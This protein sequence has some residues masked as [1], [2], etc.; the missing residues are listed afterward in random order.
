MGSLFRLIRGEFKK[1]FLKPGIFIMTGLLVLV[2]TVSPKLFTPASR[3]DLILDGPAGQSVDQKL[4]NFNITAAN[5]VAEIEKTK[6][7][8]DFLLALSTTNNPAK[9]LND[10]IYSENEITY[11][12]NT[13]FK[14]Y[15]N[16]VAM[17]INYNTSKA[18]LQNLLTTYKESLQ[19]YAE[20]SL[21]FPQIFITKDNYEK[22]TKVLNDFIGKLA[23]VDGS[24]A[25]NKDVVLYASDKEYI[26]SIKQYSKNIVNISFS[27]AN[28]QKYLEEYYERTVATTGRL[29]LIKADLLTWM[30]TLVGDERELS[31]YL[32]EF[33]S[34]AINYYYTAKLANDLLEDGLYYDISKNYSD[35]QLTKYMGFENFSTYGTKESFA[36][37]QFLFKTNTNN[38]NYSNPFAFN[39]NSTEETNG[40]DYMYFVLEVMS[41]IIITY[42][43]VL[44]AGMIASEQ[45][46]GTLKMLAIRPFKRWKI[47]FAKIFTTMFFVTIFILLSSLISLI[48]GVLAFDGVAKTSLVVFNGTYAFAL[49]PTLLFFIYLLSLWIKVFVFVLIAFAISTLFKTHAGSVLISVLIYILTVICIFVAGGGDWLKFIPFANMDLFKYF[50]GSFILKYSSD[51]FLTNLFISPVFGDT[52]I[53]YTSVILGSLLILLHFVIYFT[54]KNRDIN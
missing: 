36:R 27:K 39:Q 5:Y 33:D 14:K 41:F 29:A 28:L 18:K 45:S 2:L 37:N 42:G 11:G 22:L 25:S 23:A 30:Q 24:L 32:N 46:N 48:T 38:S 51:S 26:S 13:A 35:S 12:I 50:G 17:E 40:F 44:A 54:F 9:E 21:G 1:I 43:V 8:I 10:L 19:T 3:T 34:Y 31:V 53:I 52:N 6:S 4:E 47:I 16:D 15:F 49:S 20:N 7:K